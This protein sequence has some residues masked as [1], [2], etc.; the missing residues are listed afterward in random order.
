[1]SKKFLYLLLILTGLGGF[2]QTP[3][4][5]VLKQHERV[6]KE[7][8]RSFSNILDSIKKIKIRVE[9]FSED[10]S[11][12]G[13]RIVSN[14]ERAL[15][16]PKLT[17]GGYVSAYYAV[18]SDTADANNFQKFP[19]TAPQSNAFSLNLA[20]ISAKYSSNSLRAITVL[21]FGDMPRS[22]WSPVYNYI[23]EANA[24]LRLFKKVWLDAG[25]FRT[26]IGLESIQP[27]ENIASSVAILTFFEPYYLA[28]AKLSVLASDKLTLQ[29]NAFN[30]YN[31]FT[32]TNKKKALG[33]SCIYDVSS[34][35]SITF[36]SL[37]N[38][39]SPD[40][41]K[42]HL[43][44]LYN[45][46]Y[47]IYKTQRLVLGLEANYGFQQNT[48][49][50]PA[51]P[52]KTAQMFSAL[53]EAKVML[54]KKLFIYG[55]AEYFNDQDEMLTGPE[56]NQNKQLIGLT[57]GGATLGVEYKPLQNTYLRL[58]GRELETQGNNEEIFFYN[59]KSSN[60]RY[61]LMCSLGVWF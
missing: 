38:D 21:H 33:F 1:M 60:V 50:D 9:H 43:G 18:Y 16:A 30:S 52:Q 6:L 7:H 4:D 28:G 14:E 36:N 26:H 48:S 31:G 42:I 59:G 8:E 53:A 12:T 41:S 24:G 61:E 27:R 56:I 40:T 39:D 57:V 37:W 51:V 25:F 29:L 58:E 2:A 13:T 3:A 17:I 47:M 46:L 45:N 49:I 22:V 5:S 32:E 23:Q 55:R 20:Q 11:L 15:E 34:K 44:R 19:T 10:L 54:V 35:L